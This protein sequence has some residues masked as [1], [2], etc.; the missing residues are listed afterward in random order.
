MTLEII[1]NVTGETVRRY[2]SDDPADAPVEGRNIPDYWIR[3]RRRLRDHGRVCI[4]SSGTCATRRRPLIA[5]T[6]PIAAVAASNRF[7]E[8]MFLLAPFEHIVKT[9]RSLAAPRWQ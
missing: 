2:S 4:A 1:D 6:Y 9:R 5:S 7:F 8:S 3:P